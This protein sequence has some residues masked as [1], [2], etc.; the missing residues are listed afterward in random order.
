MT[1]QSA[2]ADVIDAIYDAVNGSATLAAYP[3]NA[4]RLAVYDGPPIDDRSALIEIRIGATGEDYDEIAA[5]IAQVWQSTD[6]Q[7]DETIDVP[8]CIWTR[9]GSTDVRTWRRRTSDVFNI[10]AGLLAGNTFGLTHL[11]TTEVSAGNLREIQAAD[12]AALVLAFTVHVMG[13]LP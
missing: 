7:R 2:F 9:Q 11:F 5:D 6:G 8:C 1:S 13:S 4:Y 12:G 10:V 3:A